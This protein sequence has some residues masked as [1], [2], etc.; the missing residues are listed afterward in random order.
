MPLR[1]PILTPLALAI[2]S[3]GLATAC[4]PVAADA[5]AHDRAS[6]GQISRPAGARLI[7][8]VRQILDPAYRAGPAPPRLRTLPTGR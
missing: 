7:Q 3:L 6:A 2:L 1:R 4:G 8:R 5:A